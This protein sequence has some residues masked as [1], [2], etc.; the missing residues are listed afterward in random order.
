MENKLAIRDVTWNDLEAVSKID[1]MEDDLMEVRGMSD[2]AIPMVLIESCVVS[3]NRICRC[4][5]EVATGQIIG[6]YGVTDKNMIWFLSDKKLKEH[7][8]EFVR[9]TKEEF[10]ILTEGVD[11]AF[12]YV[13]WRHQ[14]ALRWLSWLGFTR[15]VDFVHFPPKTERYFQLE[16]YKE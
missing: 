3:F 5:Y 2:A 7:W 15:K 12:N 14:R 6:V 9:G 16:F 13:H 10:Q 8:K 4:F 1:L 11:Y